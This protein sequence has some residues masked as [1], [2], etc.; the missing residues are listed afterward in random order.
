[1]QLAQ[2]AELQLLG[3]L[4]VQVHSRVLLVE[5]QLVQNFALAQILELGESH[6]LAHQLWVLWLILELLNLV[7]LVSMF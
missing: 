4:I 3:L 2:L 7:L 1:V 6:P 5:L